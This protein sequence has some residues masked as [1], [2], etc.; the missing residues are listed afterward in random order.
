[1]LET[2]WAVGQVLDAIEA[3]GEADNTLIVFTADNGTSSVAKL[4]D[5][6]SKGV[7]LNYHFRGH[8]AQIY[9]GGHRV[10]TLVKWP[11]KISAG[12]RNDQTICLNDFFATF[13]EISGHRI[14]DDQA[15]DSVSLLALMTGSKEKLN[16][17]PLVVHHSYAGQFSI[18][19]KQWKLI[20]PLEKGG[21]PILYNLEADIKESKNIAKNHP[22]VVRELSDA[23]IKIV[24]QGRSTPGKQQ[25]NYQGKKSWRGLPESN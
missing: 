24:S 13:A 10:P 18:R 8:K 16:E 20:L 23:L 22:E 4:G 21:A 1:M 19:N 3:S 17:R 7:D 9:E 14:E 2:D 15:E 6:K 12:R 11:G 25:Q 5:L